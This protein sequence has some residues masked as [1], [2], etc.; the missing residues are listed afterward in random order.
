MAKTHD[1][2]PGRHF[3]IAIYL[4]VFGLGISILNFLIAPGQENVYEVADLSY[5]KVLRLFEQQQGDIIVIHD[6]GADTLKS[7]ED[8]IFLRDR[9]AQIEAENES[10]FE[11]ALQPIPVSSNSSLERNFPVLRLDIAGERVKGNPLEFTIE[12]YD[13]KLTYY[14]DFGNGSRKQIGRVNTFTYAQAGWF[15]I[16]L[17]A[18]RSGREE[19]HVYAKTI[20]IIP[21]SSQRPSYQNPDWVEVDPTKEP[22]S[23]NLPSEELITNSN[24]LE[25]SD[26]WS[27]ESNSEI[28]DIQSLELEDLNKNVADSTL[29]DVEIIP[30]P[31]PQK[32]AVTTSNKVKETGP[33]LFAEVMPEFPG[34]LAAMRRYF[35]KHAKYPM[36]AQNNRIQGTVHV[37]AVVGTTGKLTDI[38]VIKGIGYGCDEESI[39]LV[40]QMPRWIPGTQDGVPVP[41][42]KVVPVN[43]KLLN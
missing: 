4:A 38:K 3:Y 12:D 15:H 19:Q 43:F 1:R 26:L 35:G 27:E 41:V 34:G 16:R 10:E 33:N 40:K 11:E 28:T 32:S 18:S 31:L 2:R 8:Y 42:Y 14:L 36:K 22:S 13:P 23:S 6:A 21:A 25:V 9:L 30:N 5:S 7:M 39:R 24:D 20:Q 17:I 29:S 37:R